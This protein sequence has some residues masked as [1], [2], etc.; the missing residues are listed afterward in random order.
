MGLQIKGWIWGGGVVFTHRCPARRC[1]VEIEAPSGINAASLVTAPWPANV[2]PPPSDFSFAVRGNNIGLIE[3]AASAQRDV[4]NLFLLSTTAPTTTTTTTRPHSGE[5]ELDPAHED[6]QE[7][8]TL[9]QQSWKHCTGNK[10]FTDGDRSGAG[11]GVAS[12]A[13]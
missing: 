10:R 2:P 3:A 11:S 6:V 13:R 8:E 5:R 4:R 12:R 7:E 1:C 9:Q